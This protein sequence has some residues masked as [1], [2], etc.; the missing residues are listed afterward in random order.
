MPRPYNRRTT[1]IV[2][3]RARELSDAR[4]AVEKGKQLRATRFT[5]AHCVRCIVRRCAREICTYIMP[6]QTNVLFALNPTRIPNDIPNEFRNNAHAVA[7]Y[8]VSERGT[9]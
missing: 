7:R 2:E 6:A 4:I 1:N 3:R 8:F 5:L 9:S